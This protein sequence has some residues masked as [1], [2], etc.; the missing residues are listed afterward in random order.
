VQYHSLFRPLMQLLRLLGPWLVAT[1][2][3]RLLARKSTSFYLIC[4]I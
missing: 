2:P 1:F 3:A 4:L